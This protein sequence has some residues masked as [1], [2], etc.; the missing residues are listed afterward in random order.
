M[1]EDKS[2][3]QGLMSKV[4]SNAK[5]DATLDFGR[6][7][8]DSPKAQQ[9]TLDFGQGTLDSRSHCSLKFQTEGEGEE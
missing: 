8:L 7:T 6:E 1:N 3:V 5:Q 9:S 4:I 2:K